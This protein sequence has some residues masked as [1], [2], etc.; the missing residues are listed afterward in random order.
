MRRIG[1]LVGLCGL[2]VLVGAGGEQL[3]HF[4]LHKFSI[5]PLEAPPE[6]AH[7]TVLS[8]LLPATGGFSPNV[9]VAVQQS[10]GSLD[11]YIALSERGFQQ[12]GLKVLKNEKQGKDAV[13]MEY[14]GEM[15]NR[16]LH[17]YARAI[18]SGDHVLLATAA[19]TEE[20]WP[21]AQAKL[22]GCVDSFRRE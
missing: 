21:T 6:G 17:F 18:V 11:N 19:A 20:Q 5:A 22:K 16:A 9:N 8:M 12:A 15:Q 4:P 14:A 7:S 3:L 10:P 13:L 2:F 1:F